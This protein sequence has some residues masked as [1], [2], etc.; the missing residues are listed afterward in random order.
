MCMKKKKVFGL[1]FFV[2]SLILSVIIISLYDNMKGRILS[3]DLNIEW[4]VEWRLESNLD[5]LILD[6]S[7][8][9]N[10]TYEILTFV[11]VS[12][13]AQDDIMGH[14][15]RDIN[16]SKTILEEDSN[17][18]F[19][20]TNKITEESISSGKF[21]LVNKDKS[22]FVKKYAYAD[23]LYLYDW[24]EKHY[25]I[26]Y[27]FIE[28]ESVE[29]DV[30]I[31]Y[32]T[33]Q[34]EKVNIRNIHFQ[35]PK[36]ISVT[37][38]IPRVIQ[39]NGGLISKSL[40]GFHS[41]SL[42]SMLS[43][44][45]VFVVMGLLLI[46]YP[47]Q[48]VR[49][50]HP[51]RFMA[52]QKI[53]SSTLLIGAGVCL[54]ILFLNTV[55]NATLDGDLIKYIDKIGFPSS[56]SIVI[57][58]NFIV[59]ML[60]CLFMALAW[61]YIKY[62]LS[63]IN[64]NFIKEKSIIYSIL[65]KIKKALDK[66]L[67]IDFSNKL[68]RSIAI[69]L[70]INVIV[71]IFLGYFKTLGTILMIGIGVATF[72]W[73][74]TKLLKIQAEYQLLLNVT[75]QLGEGKFNQKINEEFETFNE[76][77]EDFMKVQVGFEK[78][79][80]EETKSQNMKTEL[81]SNVSHDLKTPLTCIKNYIELLQ[82]VTLDDITREEYLQNLNYYSERLRTLIEDLFEVSKVNSGNVHL[83]L[84]DLNIVSLIEQVETEHLELL[85]ERNLQVIIS[86]FANEIPV[87]LDS[88]KTYRIFENLFTNI[89]KYAMPNTRVY[90]SIKEREDCVEVEI[91]NISESPM[92]F[93][94]EEIVE[95]FV[96]GDKARHEQGSG[97]GLAIVK[98]FTE[99]Q[100]G[101]FSIAIDGDLFKTTVSFYKSKNSI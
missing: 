36:N 100:N 1:V 63:S 16:N 89:S 64:Q 88:N 78:A 2:I 28:G 67:V 11:D 42:F 98:S 22:S 13:A 51:F 62:L 47:I 48:T 27:D 93:S 95:R 12:K 30:E 43:M 10:S 3:N 41:Y 85:Q 54:E 94:A 60:C 86:R 26:K 55:P 57:G 56:N 6:K 74:Y 92:N 38:V 97:L 40:N 70:V 69:Y 18:E 24:L 4:D 82:D 25:T 77:R 53:E 23:S 101:I 90:I 29:E 19:I 83:D 5:Y 52:S 81:I 75:K 45:G 61:F 17:F 33:I 80:E 99:I 39:D 65:S 73:I 14:L 21:E 15:Q 91:K 49:E 58:I 96:R 46:F 59:W 76:L 50:V 68:Y 79:V 84:V 71:V 7:R 72:Y 66:I 8:E 34:G 87:Y 31:E 32:I 35:K 44:F 9:L 20:I 37:Y